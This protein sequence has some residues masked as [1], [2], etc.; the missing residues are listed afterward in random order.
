MEIEFGSILK[1]FSGPPAPKQKVLR[2]NGES[3][4]KRKKLESQS[5]T[6]NVINDVLMERIGSGCMTIARDRMAWNLLREAYAL[7]L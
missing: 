7:R 3:F 5:V 6:K 2:C 1:Y 4:D